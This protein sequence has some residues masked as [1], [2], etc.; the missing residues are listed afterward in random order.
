MRVVWTSFRSNMPIKFS[1]GELPLS[2]KLQCIV[3][4]LFHF[5]VLYFTMHIFGLLGFCEYPLFETIFSQLPILGAQL[6]YET[7]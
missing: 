2:T 5:T 7:D 4:Y 3:A 1:L 6:G